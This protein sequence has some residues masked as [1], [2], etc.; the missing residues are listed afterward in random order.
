VGPDFAI[1]D[2]TIAP[3]AAGG[4]LPFAPAEATAALLAM[5]R[6]H[7]AHLWSDYGFFDAFNPAFDF[8]HVPVRHGRVVPGAGWYDSDYLGID[9]G[10][11]LA[12]VEN[13]RSGLVWRVMRGN[14]HLVRGLRRAGFSG[15]W[16]N[17]PAG[18]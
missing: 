17:E 7:G 14:P 8:E 5:R 16:L 11:I 12:M 15:G 9:Q 6:R 10:P 3:A 18:R 1:D 13:H 4:S 2:G